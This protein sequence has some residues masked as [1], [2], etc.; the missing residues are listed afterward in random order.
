VSGRVAL[1]RA[2]SGAPAVLAGSERPPGVH[3]TLVDV[4]YLPRPAQEGRAARLLA[5]GRP[6]LFTGPSLVGKTRLAAYVAE[7]LGA[8]RPLLV[9]ADPTE[10]RELAEG[11][12][13]GRVL[14]LDDLERYLSPDLTPAV[15][16]A[17][18]ARNLVLATM[19]AD[20]VERFHPG[21][22]PRPTGA[23]VLAPFEEIRLEPR[24][25]EDARGLDDR[26]RERIDELGVG[27]YAGGAQRLA[28]EVAWTRA[29][30][31]L[32]Y[33]LLAGAADWRRA[34]LTRPV[35]VEVLVHLARAHVRG[36]PDAA[37]WDSA[38][39]WACGEVAPGTTLLRAVHHEGYAVHSYVGEVLRASAGHLP[40]ASWELVLR[41]ARPEELATVASAAAR[42]DN[43][44][45]V[46]ERSLAAAGHA[47]LPEAMSALAAVLETLP[48]RAGAARR[49]WQRAAAAGDPVA[50]GLLGCRLLD[51][52]ALDGAARWCDLAAGLGDAGAMSGLARLAE[53]DGRPADAADWWARAAAAGHAGAS[54]RL[55]VAAL[56]AGDPV[57]AAAHWR[58]A[59][60]LGDPA[61]ANDLGVWHR[62]RGEWR[63]AAARFAWAARRGHL[64]A[65]VNLG[66]LLDERG[67]PDDAEHW[68]GTA[69]AAGLPDAMN[70]LAALLLD[71]GDSDEALRWFR[72]AADAEDPRGMHNLATLLDARGETSEARTWWRRAVKAGHP[73]AAAALAACRERTE[74][75]W[76]AAADTG[77][78]AAMY[79]LG[80]LAERRGDLAAAESWWRRAGAGGDRD[81]MFNLAAL[82]AEHG[83]AEQAERWYS[84]AAAAGDAD[85]AYNLGVLLAG[86]GDLGSARLRLEAAA[87]TGHVRAM[88]ALGAVAAGSD[89]DAAAET[90]WRRAADAGDAAAMHNLAMLLRDLGRRP[91]AEVWW[92]RSAAVG[93]LTEG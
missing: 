39:S 1:P 76:R 17:L 42:E 59:A 20:A 86:R 11:G 64:R 26:A 2:R 29:R 10:L 53:A 84:R 72:R 44:A 25:A 22:A 49:W 13:G 5:A 71:R 14:W 30:H 8:D 90:W 75:R 35:P 91:E 19:G 43:A 93:A 37:D 41:A 52:G 51:E 67:R 69:A 70:N 66:V 7:R 28:A 9:P 23:D 40:A 38:L 45:L 16:A 60:D 21:R 12:V 31:P 77:D 50:M 34:G 74:Q 88:L 4:P 46:L 79:D 15:I 89:D 85:A 32:V 87:A 65:M 54:H 24:R 63:P 61:A 57:A 33:A 68:F 78:L 18:A 83:E 27:A 6:V 56:E 36:R 47:G 81:A 80:V 3:P 73:G 48:G 92:L 62:D 82:L 55:G 58:R